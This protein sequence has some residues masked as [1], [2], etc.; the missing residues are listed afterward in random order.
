MDINLLI[1]REKVFI[2]NICDKYNYDT[3]IRHILWI[4]IP[5]F[6]MKYGLD[7]EKL[8]LD[9]FKNTTIYSSN[10]DS[11]MI[12]AYYSSILVKR[13]DNY[14]TIKKMVIHN[15]NKITLVELVD[16]LA[17]EF[18]HAINSYSNEIKVDDKYIYLRTG[19]TYRIYNKKTLSFIKKDS[20]FILEEIINTKQTEDVINII[21]NMK[22]KD[23][24]L[25]NTVYAINSE[26]NNK[27][28]SSSYNLQSSICRKIME[29]RTF[30]STLEKLRLAGEIYDIEKW[31]DDIVGENNK[32]KEFITLLN[33]IY[34]L[35]ILY[36]EK[37]YFKSRLLN[38]IRNKSNK[39]LLIVNKFNE[40]VI[41]R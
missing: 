4:I 29:N 20:S 27:Y 12:R 37:K 25:N 41:F 31:F 5:A 34:E 32:Y 7:K 3:N 2:D 6:I 24:T 38:K 23:S 9:T 40:N 14:N 33:E 18:N 16:T 13:N 35:E 36:N 28:N 10:K 15:Y 8:V 39:I 22:L 26:T 17:H 11:Q 21:K 1:E 19:L 30:I